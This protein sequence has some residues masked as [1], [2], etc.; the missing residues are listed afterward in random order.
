MRRRLDLELVRRGLVDTRSEATIAIRDGRVTVGGRP[1]TKAG[2]LIAPEDAVALATAARA[3]ASRGGE[4]LAGALD[5]LGVDPSG[6]RA[7]DA[8]A[9]TGGFTDCLLR[10]GVDHVVAVDV[11]YGQLDWRLRGD[12]R[13]TVQER[14]NVR[15]LDPAS[16]PYR[17]DLVVADLSFISLRVVLP[18]LVRCAAPGAEF[19]LLVKPQF[20]A[21][22]AH[23]GA[24]GV[25]ADP[26]V[27]GRVLRDVAAAAAGEG[28]AVW[29]I[30]VSPLLGPAGNAEFFLRARAPGP[31][32]IG[33]Q[34]G[35]PA[36][37]GMP[38]WREALGAWVAEAVAGASALRA[39]RAA[40]GREERPGE[41]APEED[42]GE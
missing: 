19:V 35:G 37:P 39:A 2:T 18:A 28:L 6:C 33:L 41:A 14:T 8:G 31:P 22:R 36:G 12:P 16:L 3:F 7:L 23:V 20:E 15:D 10:R 21:G 38:E 32:R 40:G 24:R 25:V 17:P 13:V 42:E 27:W 9:S 4:K 11:G 30:C 34:V 5:R 29:G 26:E 1:A